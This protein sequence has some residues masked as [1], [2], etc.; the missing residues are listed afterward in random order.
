[1]DESSLGEV[2]GYKIPSKGE[3]GSAKSKACPIDPGDFAKTILKDIFSSP[4]IS[5]LDYGI[6]MISS[7]SP[8]RFEGHDPGFRQPNL[9]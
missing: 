9:R 4:S 5:I 6:N 2:P 3:H 8:F 7:I 1:M